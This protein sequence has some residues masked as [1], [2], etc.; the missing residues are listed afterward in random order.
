MP[1]KT[2][3]PRDGTSDREKWRARTSGLGPLETRL[4]EILW[5]REEAASVREVQLAYHELAYTTI[6]TTL[7]RLYRK[8]LLIRERDGRAF[9]YRPRCTRDQLLSELVFDN[10]TGP[11]GASEQSR[12]VLST[13]V[14]A[15][16]GADAA[17]LDELEAL[18]QAERVRRGHPTK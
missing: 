13:F 16:S 4:L 3:R 12:I 14:R 17:L 11:L 2:L 5:A 15:V 7:D 9:V 1:P 10:L 6:M 8:G 18:I